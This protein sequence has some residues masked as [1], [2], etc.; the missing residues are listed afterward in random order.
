MTAGLWTHKWCPICFLLVVDDF[1]VKYVGQEHADHLIVVLEET[2]KIEVDTKRD[3]YVGI[4]L[5]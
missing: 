1:G 2:Y 4:S 3:K 5:D